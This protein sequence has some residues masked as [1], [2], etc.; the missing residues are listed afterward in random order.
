MDS[1]KEAH[2]ILCQALETLA[3]S[4]K[5]LNSFHGQKSDE[6]AM[7]RDSVIQRFEYSIDRFWKYLMVYLEWQGISVPVMD[8]SPR[9]IIRLAR[10]SS[11]VSSKEF[12]LLFGAI[13]DR[14]RTSHAYDAELAETIAD[15]I[16]QYYETLNTIIKRLKVE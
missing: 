4:L 2:D 5:K 15:K 3:M 11:T 7:I 14:N 8:R 1:I 16:Y 13:E 12:G 9:A 10:D 6:Q